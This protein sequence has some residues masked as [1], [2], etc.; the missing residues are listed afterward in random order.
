M[1]DNLQAVAKLANGSL[2]HNSPDNMV[3]TKDINALYTGIETENSVGT[4]ANLAAL[5]SIGAV[6]G[7]VLGAVLG[8]GG[9]SVPGA[10][11]GAAI[12]S[13]ALIGLGHMVMKATDSYGRDERNQ[14]REHIYRQLHAKIEQ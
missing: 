13:S 6:G 12:G 7:G 4:T 1:E 14:E 11:L 5:G 10:A 8:A 9:L 3:S 2:E